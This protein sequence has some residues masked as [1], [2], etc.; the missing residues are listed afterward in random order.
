MAEINIPIKAEIQEL[1]DKLNL[2]KKD[3]ENIST[4]AKEAGATISKGFSGNNI[5][6]TNKELKRTNGL[7]EDIEEAI[8]EWDIAKKKA[9]DIKEIEKYNRKIA[10]GK[11]ELQEYNTKGLPAMKNINAE[12]T[13]G[14]SIFAGLGAKIAAAFSVYAVINFAKEALNAY[15]MQLK[16]EMKLKAALGE[17]GAMFEALKKQSEELRESTA[18][19]DETI[20]SAQSFLAVQG[21]TEKQIKKMTETALDLSVVLGTDVLTATKYL[22]QTFDQLS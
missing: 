2:V 10:E 14:Q 3:I 19:D 1:L 11:K 17:R 18:I 22:D 15:N 9:T 21:R 12:A 8:K 5:T 16:N 13:K 6:S 20:L 7:I 4:P